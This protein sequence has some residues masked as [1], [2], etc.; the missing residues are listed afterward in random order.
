M[1]TIGNFTRDK[2]GYAGAIRTLTVNMKARLVPNDARKS[3]SAPDYRIFSGQAARQL[4]ALMAQPPM[5]RE[6]NK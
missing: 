4:T 3:E 5:G 2:T 6:K 1:A